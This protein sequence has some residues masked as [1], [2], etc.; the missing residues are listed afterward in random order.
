MAKMEDVESVLIASEF[1]HC[2][3]PFALSKSKAIKKCLNGFKLLCQTFKEVIESMFFEPVKL[4]AF[5]IRLHARMY[6]VFESAN[7]MSSG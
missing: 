6:L 7:C 5:P 4:I 2:D 3:N 1:Q